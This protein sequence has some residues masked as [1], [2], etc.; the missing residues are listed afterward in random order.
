[1]RRE[2]SEAGATEAE[3]ALDSLE[4]LGR[5]W[6]AF[7]MEPPPW[8]A[9]GF[10]ERRRVQKLMPQPPALPDGLVGECLHALA[11][12]AASLP[13]DFAPE[14]VAR[15]AAALLRMPLRIFGGAAH[16][17]DLLRQKCEGAGGDVIAG[18]P[19]DQ[20]REEK[21]GFVFQLESSEVRAACVVLACSS[22]RIG[23]LVQGG[24]RT[25]R[26]VGEEAA[27][28]VE[29]KVA[30]A[31]FV[32]RPEGLPQ[33]LDEVA[34]LVG[35]RLGPLVLAV[36]PARKVRGETAGERLLSVARIVDAGF[37]DEVS[38]VGSIR[39]A[40]EP[41]AP[42]LR[43]ARGPPGRRPEPCPAALHPA[44]PGKRGVGGLRPISEASERLLFASGA[45]YPGFGLEGQLLAARA[46]SVQALALSGR[47]TV[48]A[49]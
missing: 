32:I 21:K 26:K 47:K 24:G 10:F 6:D 16:L 45:T 44:R 17:A 18:Q 23:A 14:S 1:M 13:A 39:A 35:N 49:T 30:L 27:L 48:S 38:P 3:A 2:L 25:E 20:L 41:G 42:L 40:L 36:L 5:T 8:P 4:A 11:P 34:L 15:E 29:R 28:P 19:A 33:A 7:L 22:D 46:A 9:R 31:H 37:S 43:P 12:F